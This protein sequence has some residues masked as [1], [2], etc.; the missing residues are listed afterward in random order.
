[1]QDARPG[2]ALLPDPRRVATRTFVLVAVLLA[3]A[4]AFTTLYLQDRAAAERQ[5]AATHTALRL[6]DWVGGRLLVL[7]SCRAMRTEGL[8]AEESDWRD[9]VALE[10]GVVEG[11]QAINWI[12]PGG[13]ISIVAP[14]SGNEGAQGKSVRNH[15][16]AGPVFARATEERR[17]AASPPLTLFQGG[18]GFTT[19]LPVPSR[20]GELLGFVNGVF[21]LDV[22]AAQALD[23]V[24]PH[25]HHVVVEDDGLTVWDTDPDDPDRSG[26]RR[27]AVP[28]ADRQ[29][30]VTVLPAAPIVPLWWHLWA[31]G[32]VAL[33]AG[34]AALTTH[35][36][37]ANARRVA[38]ARAER[39]RISR[40]LVELERLE[41]L[42]RVAGGIAHD[43]NN[44]LAVVIGRASELEARLG[45][46]RPDLDEGV[47]G[48]LD[49]GDRG[50]QLV[51]SLLA[52]ARRGDDE[53]GLVD[54]AAQ[55]RDL[56]A[57]LR[58]LGGRYV[59]VTVEVDVEE[60]RVGLAPVAFDRL[61]INLVSNAVHAIPERGRV[62]VS[63][64]ARGSHAVL[65]VQD[66]GVGM[67]EQTRAR[68]FEPF[69]TTRDEGTG[70]GLSNV[71]GLVEDAGGRV[72]L[73][74]EPGAGSRFEIWLP[75][76]PP[77][78]PSSAG[79]Y[80]G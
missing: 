19:Y 15:A 5:A 71:R 69:F 7:E 14:A 59:R 12:E 79:R 65:T 66:D 4:W 23:H 62:Q 39:E 36:S 26:A 3:G 10:L 63:L 72:E 17:L 52:F 46:S 1:M 29:W 50:A 18:Q 30:L 13:E 67:A 28:I 77:G 32:G 20:H 64:V 6:Q 27:A 49:A 56:S 35:R 54:A 8:L 31:V 37:A 57:M 25:A 73:Q 45:D 38:E 61:V 42:G 53:G 78:E 43:F 44:V 74:S 68:V 47:Q 21:R 34:V 2:P 33:A 70:L 24:D 76:L 16:Q 40:R 60:A 11:L 58:H 9:W 41:S 51:R 55:L 80:V 48:I 22:M 75:L